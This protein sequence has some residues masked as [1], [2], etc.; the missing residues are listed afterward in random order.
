MGMLIKGYFVPLFFTIAFLP[1]LPSILFVDYI[2]LFSAFLILCLAISWHGEEQSTQIREELYNAGASNIIEAS[3]YRYSFDQKDEASILR[4][5]G[6]KFLAPD[7]G[8]QAY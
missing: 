6:F 3:S 7:E 8:S 5:I 4:S 1:V 2:V